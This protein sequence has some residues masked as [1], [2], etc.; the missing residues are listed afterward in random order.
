MSRDVLVA[1]VVV[2]IPY[3]CVLGDV[4]FLRTRPVDG[5]EDTPLV[6]FGEGIEPM[7]VLLDPVLDELEE[8]MRTTCG[9][10]AGVRSRESPARWGAG[11]AAL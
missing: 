9:K 7:I 5:V 8:T 2:Q 3:L 10:R 1:V 11:H 4:L 6:D